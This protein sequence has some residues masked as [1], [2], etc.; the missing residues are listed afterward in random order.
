[1]VAGDYV[2]GNDILGS[3][4]NGDA[5]TAYAAINGNIDT[6]NI[7]PSGA[8]IKGTQL[9]SAPD[10]VAAANINTD[11]VETAKIKDLNVT[12]G[13]LAASAV[14]LDKTKIQVERV[15]FAAAGVVNAAV[16]NNT[17]H[18]LLGFYTDTITGGTHHSFRTTTTS[19]SVTVGLITG[20]GP[21]AGAVNFVFIDRT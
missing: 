15:T 14:T 18:L 20:A 6:N 8:G 12:K 1:M 17:T 3:E 11:A 19:N 9:A 4:A 13:K 21:L 10:G 7:K 16:F 2:A 5:N